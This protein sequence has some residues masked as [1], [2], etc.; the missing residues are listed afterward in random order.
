MIVCNAPSTATSESVPLY[1]RICKDV[2]STGGSV[3]SICV[4]PL[5]TYATF[6]SCIM[7][8]KNISKLCS[9]SISEPESFSTLKGCL[10]SVIVKTFLRPS[11][12]SEKS[13][14][15]CN[16]PNTHPAN[17]SSLVSVTVNTA[18]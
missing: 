3:N 6:G 18:F 14:K 1:R 2:P 4:P 13:S 17:S 16:L 7:S 15:T 5:K 11:N 12:S 9:N 10:F 8:F